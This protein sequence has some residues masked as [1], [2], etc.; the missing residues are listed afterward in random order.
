MSQELEAPYGKGE[1]IYYEDL[2][3][4]HT[5]E[6]GSYR[7]DKEEII[8]FASEWDPQP[9]HIDEEAA[10]QS[11]FGCLTGSSIHM[12]AVMSK[13]IAFRTG[14]LA[15]LAN[16]STAFDNPNPMRAGVTLSFNSTTVDKRLSKSRPGV[17]I[18]SFEAQ[19]TDDDGL[20]VMN[21]RSTVMIACR[22][23]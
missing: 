10:R 13:V 8:A 17:G 6:L 2:V 7:V 3:I 18:V 11:M 23:D 19:A 9:F 22:P 16:L 4:G 5:R 1:K 12:L 21:H 14:N 20:V 15:A